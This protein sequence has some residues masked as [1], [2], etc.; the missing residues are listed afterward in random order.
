MQAELVIADLLL[1]LALFVALLPEAAAAL[2]CL[3]VQ[4]QVQ[5]HI[6]RRQALV[7]CLQEFT[8]M[9]LRVCM[10]LDITCLISFLLPAAHTACGS[11]DAGACAFDILQ[12]G[13][14][15]GTP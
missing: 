13:L 14:S 8:W 9:S 4:H 11:E 6:W 10:R 12:L 7:W 3:N 5:H 2:R 1:Q 15:L